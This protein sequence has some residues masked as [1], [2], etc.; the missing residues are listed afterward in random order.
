MND[1]IRIALW[2]FF[3]RNYIHINYFLVKPKTL[4]SKIGLGVSSILTFSI[5]LGSS[6]KRQIQLISLTASNIE[7]LSPFI[8]SLHL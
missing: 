4:T 5:K 1:V 6:L 7:H 2:R 8:S 3:P